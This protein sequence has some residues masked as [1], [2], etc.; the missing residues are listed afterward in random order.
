MSRECHC[1]EWVIRCAH[2]DDQTIAVGDAFLM[3][4]EPGFF[5]IG[6]RYALVD[7]RFSE[8]TQHVVGYPFRNSPGLITTFDSEADAL[9]AFY[10]A[11]RELLETARALA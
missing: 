3:K 8:N 1:P 10:E 11:E 6:R 2:F 5:H 4:C 7:P 9:A